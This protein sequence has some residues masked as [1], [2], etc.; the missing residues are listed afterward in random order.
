M[1]PTT[2]QI[3]RGAEGL[4]AA[5]AFAGYYRL[6][7]LR[8]RTEPVWAAVDMLVVPTYPRPVTLAEI[9]ADPIGPN[10]GLGTYTNFV[11]LLDL[12]ALAV[13]GPFRSD[14][15]PAGVTLIGPAG[16]DATLATTAAAFH[17]ATHLSLGATGEA[18]PAQIDFQTTTQPIRPRPSRSSLWARISRGCPSI[19]TWLR[20]VRRW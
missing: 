18:Q 14:R 8:R 12:C 1:H 16:H 10:S 4:S 13:P 7:A 11:N 6:A 17:H 5:D 19:A 2:L 20:S 9:A 3:T 15:Q